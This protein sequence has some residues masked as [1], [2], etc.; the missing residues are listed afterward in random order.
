ML[1]LVLAIKFIQSQILIF[2]LFNSLALSLFE[3]HWYGI[4]LLGHECFLHII[5]VN[6]S[7]I[8]IFEKVYH[9]STPITL[10]LHWASASFCRRY[11]VTLLGQVSG[12]KVEWRL[13]WQMMKYL[14]LINHFPNCCVHFLESSVHRLWKLSIN[15]DLYLVSDFSA[16]LFSRWNGDLL[17]LLGYWVILEFFKGFGSDCFALLEAF[18]LILKLLLHLFF[19]SIDIS[20]C[21][22]LVLL[23]KE[24]I[25]LVIVDL[26]AY[27]ILTHFFFIL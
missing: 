9:T 19:S 1:K 10:F 18:E 24:L 11:W 5:W 23:L 20:D 3:H 8:F 7:C 16:L 6:T 21:V 14:L 4:L 15:L 25:V 27:F 13:G 12:A 22:F 26:L 2:K 17:F